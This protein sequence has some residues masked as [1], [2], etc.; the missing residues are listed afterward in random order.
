ENGLRLRIYG[1][2]GGLEW[3]QE[4]PNHLWFTPFG[5]PRRRLTRGGAGTGPA[6]AAVTRVPS[7]HP[8]GY[9]EAFATLYREAAVAIRT[10]R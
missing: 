7:G 4:N 1:D 10:A 5:E 3:E 8:E 2:K 9:L 6:A